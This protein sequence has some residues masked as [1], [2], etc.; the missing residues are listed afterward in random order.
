M[1]FQLNPYQEDKIVSCINGEIFDVAVD[2]REDSPT[3]LNYYGEI[4]SHENN[5]SMCI[6]KGFA[7]GF[8]SLSSDC[9]VLYFHTEFYSSKFERG[10]RWDDQLLKIDWP[11]PVTNLSERDMGHKLLN[12]SFKGIKI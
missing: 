5:K 2:I 6:P 11:L 12:K 8:Q 3:F 9:E 1:H 10:L 7:H 4:L